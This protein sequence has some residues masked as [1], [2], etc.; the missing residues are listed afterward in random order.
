MTGNDPY[1]GVNAETIV[2][3]QAGALEQR[4]LHMQ[5][6]DPLRTPTYSLFPKPD[7]YFSTS[8]PNV[9]INSGFAYNHGYYSPNIDVTWSALVGPGVA[10]HGVDGPQPVDGNQP[11]DPNST[12]TV[13]Q[14]STVGTWVEETDLRPTLMYLT[15]LHEDYQTDGRVISQVLQSTPSA[16]R[17]TEQLGMAY[18]QLNSSV[19]AFAT[20]TLIAD[21]K[22]LASGSSTSDTTY[23][24]EQRAL[25]V[26]VN[27]RDALATQI[28][29]TLAAAA[30]GDTPRFATVISQLIRA[31]VINAAAHYL[32]THT[33]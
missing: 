27:Q 10:A 11:H 15:G 7:Y 32:A 31:Q 30:N 8:G 17:W 20:Y 16:L 28:K 18:Q 29:A 1:T 14:A 24:H 13:P 22:A 21:S 9:S 26:L 12:A 5:T 23:A 33:A 25:S 6:A 19:G 4:A 2:N 3:Y